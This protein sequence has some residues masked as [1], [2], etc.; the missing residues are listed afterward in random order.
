MT[1]PQEARTGGELLTALSN[2]V[3]RIVREYTG[4]GP[5]QARAS[6]RDDVVIVMMQETLLKAEHSLIN[7][8]KGALVVEMRRSFHQTM[9]QE[10]SDAVERLTGRKVIAFMSDS[11]LEPDY[12]AEIF[13][14]ESSSSGDLQDGATDLRGAAPPGDSAQEDSG[15]G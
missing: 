5:T 2:A 6:I 13:V 9:R 10:L 15:G 14:L 12:S 1:S 11:Q 7:D 8:S 3:V 4:R